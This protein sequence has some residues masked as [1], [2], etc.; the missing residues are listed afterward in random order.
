MAN[1]LLARLRKQRELNVTVGKFV[2]IANRPTDVEWVEMQQ[3]GGK[4]HEIARRF[5]HGWENVTEDDIVGGGGSDA[6]P[7]EAPLWMDWCADHYE[8]WEP[9]ANAVIESYIAHT[10][11]I[12]SA[13]GE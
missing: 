6:V 9:V 7:F 5:V 4:F 3:N 12:E 10:K 2:F 11:A 1:P 8:F 13:K